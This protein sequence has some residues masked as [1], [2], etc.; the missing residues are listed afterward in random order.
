MLQYNYSGTSL[1][2]RVPPLNE[3][4]R[5]PFAYVCSIP[6]V[7]ESICTSMW[8][9]HGSHKQTTGAFKGTNLC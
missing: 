9:D 2:S 3:S 1:E 7:G 5:S 8:M 6:R 4:V